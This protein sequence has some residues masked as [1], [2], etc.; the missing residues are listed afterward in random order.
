M[1]EDEMYVARF[2]ETPDNDIERGWSAYMC[3]FDTD[4]PREALQDIAGVIFE[5]EELDEIQQR[6]IN[7]W[8]ENYEDRETF[9]ADYFGKQ[10]EKYGLVLDP[11][12]NVYKP[13]HHDGLS[14]WA[15]EATT[16]EEAIEEAK[17]TISDFEWG[18]FGQ[19]TIGDVK[20]VAKVEGT[21]NA[22]VDAFLW[23]FECDD[24]VDE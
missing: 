10:C 23:I 16:I 13:F 11:H 5:D 2:T 9:E 12:R 18:G 20:K 8:G 7:T 1:K 6:Y 17:R 22:V 15:L 19:K 4:N 24:A 3:G 14:C 21:G